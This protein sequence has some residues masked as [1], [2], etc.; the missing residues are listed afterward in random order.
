ME[1]FLASRSSIAKPGL[2]PKAT[3]NLFSSLA[4]RTT[5]RPDHAP[6]MEKLPLPDTAEAVPHGHEPQI[7]LVRENDAVQ[8]IVVVCKCGERIEL[9]CVY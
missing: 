4:N 1:N 6:P 5:V 3:A 2:Q 7:E 9:D 8:R